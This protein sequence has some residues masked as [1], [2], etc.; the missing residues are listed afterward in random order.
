MVQN[1]RGSGS[2]NFCEIS[3]A[4]YGASVYVS[5]HMGNFASIKFAVRVKF[6]KSVKIRLRESLAVYGIC[7]PP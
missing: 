5:T 1:F 7:M 3:Y 2:N 4:V 6:V